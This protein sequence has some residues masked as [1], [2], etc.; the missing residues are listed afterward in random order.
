M[1]I[2]RS[3]LRS[4]AAYA[5]IAVGVSIFAAVIAWQGIDDVVEAFSRAGWRIVAITLLHI[6]P[7]WADAMGWGR[8]FSSERR[9]PLR[10]MLWGR[11]IGESINDLLPVLQM[12]GNVVKAWILAGHGVSVG[13]AGA[14]VVVDVTLVVLSQILFTIV[15]LVLIVPNIRS[16][17]PLLVVV[18]GAGILSMLLSGF[19]FFQRRGL[20]SIIAQI[21]RRFVGSLQWTSVFRGAAT[22][23]AEILRLYGEYRAL[24][25]SWCWHFVSWFLGIA[26]V[27]LALRLLGHPVD[28][29]TALL[30]ESLGQAIRTGA[31][32]VPGALGIQEGGY[33]LVGGVLGIEPVVALALS[34]ARRVRELLLGLPGL[35]AWQISSIHRST[36]SEPPD[37]ATPPS[38]PEGMR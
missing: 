33:V 22:I 38:A 20:F 21:S 7:L 8:L 24:I 34:L 30:F 16:G 2:F 28:V 26:E 3:I 1:K 32:A 4:H 11:W 25:A 15:G 10:T 35:L 27:W 5:G 19:Y 14:S 29:G 23:D 18:V 9:P 17:E 31:F 12:G 36:R 37:P 13:L 6:P